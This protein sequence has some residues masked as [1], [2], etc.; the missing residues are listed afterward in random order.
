MTTKDLARL[1]LSAS[2]AQRPDPDAKRPRAI[3]LAAGTLLSLCVA[4]AAWPALGQ[5]PHRLELCELGNTTI[6][7][8]QADVAADTGAEEVEVAFVVVYSLNNDNNGQVVDGEPTGPILCTN[9]ALVDSP[10]VGTNANDV[11]PPEEGTVDI[12]DS[13]EA[14]LLRYEENATTDIE[15]RFCHTVNANVDCF[16]LEPPP[17]D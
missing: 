14:F 9:G 2:R 12:F 10:P 15:T 5:E 11:I 7:N 1:C 13:S 6:T 4:G 17:S 16:S 3:G 8:L